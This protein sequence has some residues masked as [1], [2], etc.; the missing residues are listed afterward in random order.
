[1]P[2]TIGTMTDIASPFFVRRGKHPGI[3]GERQSDQQRAGHGSNASSGHDA[4]ERKEGLVGLDGSV[5]TGDFF[6]DELHANCK[7]EHATEKH[8]QESP[9]ACSGITQRFS[10]A[11]PSSP[12]NIRAFNIS[13]G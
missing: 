3:S 8:P 2:F 4:E 1:M 9:E 6:E 7:S 10:F 13:S 12:I 11:H 5:I